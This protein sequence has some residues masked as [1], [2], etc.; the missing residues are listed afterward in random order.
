MR[1]GVARMRRRMRRMMMMRKNAVGRHGEYRLLPCQ[2]SR[3][4]VV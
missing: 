4:Y 1:P 3:K 2:F